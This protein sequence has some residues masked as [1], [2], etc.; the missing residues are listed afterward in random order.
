MNVQHI[1]NIYT[2]TFTIQ[3]TV[4]LLR[5]SIFACETISRISRRHQDCGLHAC[6]HKHPHPPCEHKIHNAFTIRYVRFRAT[7]KPKKTNPSNEHHQHHRSLFA[8]ILLLHRRR[9]DVEVVSGLCELRIRRQP[10]TE[11]GLPP[12]PSPVVSPAS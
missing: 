3:C 10:T 4:L 11:Q 6:V 7:H 5:T 8:C 12:P 9:A 1:N 2:Y